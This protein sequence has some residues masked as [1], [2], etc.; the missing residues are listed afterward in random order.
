VNAERLE[1]LHE[2]VPKAARVAALVN[3]ALEA[4]RGR[5]DWLSSCGGRGSEE[6]RFADRCGKRGRYIAQSIL[7]YDQLE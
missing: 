5:D 1:L 6:H 3:P 4:S 7:F 2:L